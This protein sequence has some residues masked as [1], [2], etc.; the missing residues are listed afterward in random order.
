MAW[1]RCAVLGAP[2]LSGGL[3][4]PMRASVRSKDE[5]LHRSADKAFLIE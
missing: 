5:N 2:G 1:E 4:N 3:G